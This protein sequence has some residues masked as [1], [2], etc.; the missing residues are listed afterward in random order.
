MSTTRLARRLAQLE[1]APAWLRPWLRDRALGRAVPLVG[2]ARLRFER[3]DA[4]GVVISIAN[5]RPVQNH[6]GGVHA[7]AMA[8]LAETATGFCLG[9]HLPDD[10]LPLIKRLQVDF[11]RR[12]VGALTASAA[13]TSE[14]IARLHSEAK[15]ELLVPVTVTDESGEAPIECQMLWAW[16]PRK[17]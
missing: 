17:P 13:L 6:I 7:A 8:L 10:R 12:T 11:K 15:G 1:R 3:L 9:W 5:R 16:I 2:T 4:T 14:Q